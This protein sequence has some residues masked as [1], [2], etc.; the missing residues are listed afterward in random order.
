MMNSAGFQGSK[1]HLCKGL[2]TEAANT[3]TKLENI[4]TSTNTKEELAY[5][6]LFGRVAMYTGHLRTFGEEGVMNPRQVRE[7][8]SQ[9]LLCW[10][11]R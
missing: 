7:L 3:A 5:N 2:W 10:L 9:V 4:M 1:D 6:K 8:Q 11:Y